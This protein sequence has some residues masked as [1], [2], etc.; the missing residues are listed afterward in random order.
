MQIDLNL[1]DQFNVASYFLDQNLT[2]DRRD[3][4]AVIEGER[5]ATY[6]E[7]AD[8]ANRAGNVF[9]SLGV[10]PEQRVLLLLHDTIEYPAAFWGAIKIGAVP[11]P[12]N[13]LMRP[14]DYAYFLNDSRAKVA[15]V[16]EALW[17]QVAEVRDRLKF[18]R[19]VVVVGRA[20]EGLPA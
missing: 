10:E 20:P 12:T 15:V 13:T 8:L 17:P 11:I 2:P 16:D 1:P 5:Q 6:D 9:L 7:I 18:L 14:S 3:R 4:V 19:H